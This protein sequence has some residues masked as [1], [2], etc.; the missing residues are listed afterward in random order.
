MNP[1]AA[2]HALLTMKSLLSPGETS[3]REGSQLPV[4]RPMDAEPRV[5]LYKVRPSGYQGKIPAGLVWSKGAT[6]PW[7]TEVLLRLPR[8]ASSDLT[9][10]LSTKT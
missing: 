4:L 1:Q 9:L 10:A 7:G 6:V 2:Q 3:L 5:A 8:K